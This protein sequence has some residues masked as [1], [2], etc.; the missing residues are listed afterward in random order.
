MELQQLRHF[1][2][3]VRLG[4][5]GRA[6]EDQRITQSGLSRSI[7]NLED[8]LGLPLLKRHPKGV[9]PT[10]FGTRLIPHANALINREKSAVEDLI[11]MSK[12]HTGAVSVG[13]TWNYSHYFTPEIFTDLLSSHPGLKI[14]VKSGTYIELFESLRRDELHIV[15]GLIASGHQHPDCKVEE[16][17]TTR[18]IIVSGQNHPL[19]RKRVIKAEHLSQSEWALLESE[20]F[21]R[22]FDNFFYVAGLPIPQKTFQTN[23]FALLKHVVMNSNLLTILPREIVQEDIASKRVSH[24][25]SDTPADFTRAGLVY[26]TDAVMTPAVELVIK[27]I[28]SEAN[29]QYKNSLSEAAE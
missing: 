15:F 12:V 21:Q 26:R 27:K 22:A 6:A 7:K 16:L 25:K 29:K 5:I 24:I 10:A 14:K 8:Q 13:I 4:N 19:A 11:S 28:R 3:A 18:S 20:G 1:L 23:S 9:V 2:A 17:L